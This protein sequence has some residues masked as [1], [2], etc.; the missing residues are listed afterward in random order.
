M[1]LNQL[2]TVILLG[3]LTSLF[4]L[5]GNLFGGSAGLQFALFMAFV[6]NGIAYFFSD[7]IVLKMYGARPLDQNEYPEIYSIVNELIQKMHLPSPK[8]W[9]IDT[10]LANAFA[11]GRNQ[12]HASIAVTTGIIK[13]LDEHELRAVLAHE[14]GHVKNRDILIS[15][16]AAVIAGAIGYLMHMLYTRAWWDS[17]TSRSSDRKQN[18]PLIM[19][20]LSILV[21]FIATLLQLAIS[22]SREYLADETG[23]HACNAPLSLASALKKL[24]NSATSQSSAYEHGKYAIIAPLFI[25]HPRQTS[26][27]SIKDLFATHPPM[28]KRIEQ[29]E[30]IHKKIFSSEYKRW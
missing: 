1:F 3:V 30:L 7:T 15:T 5:I 8:L 26:S 9:I 27:F 29:L 20:A 6:M 10:P 11:T 4:L 23:A 24:Q 12:Y 18:N 17:M 28:Q 22:R 2:K 21:P 19:L 25:V 13:I 14:L 16:I